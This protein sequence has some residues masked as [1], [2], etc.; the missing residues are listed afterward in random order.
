MYAEGGRVSACFEHKAGKLL[1]TVGSGQ[2]FWRSVCSACG[3]GKKSAMKQS[4]EHADEQNRA[5]KKSCN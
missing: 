3:S 5:N 4:V 2:E 1:P